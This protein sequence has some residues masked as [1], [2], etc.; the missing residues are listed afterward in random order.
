MGNESRRKSAYQ[1]RNWERTRFEFARAL[2]ALSEKALLEILTSRH[3]RER[4]VLKRT[5]G[6]NGMP[7]QEY[8]VVA[9]EMGVTSSRI[10]QVESR[11]IFS[12]IESGVLEMP[13][14]PTEYLDQ[15]PSDKWPPQRSSL[16]ERMNDTSTIMIKRGDKWIWL[17]S[18]EEV[19]NPPQ[20]TKENTVPNFEVK[21][22]KPSPETV[23]SAK[24]THRRDAALRPGLQEGD[25]RT[26]W[27][28]KGVLSRRGEDPDVMAFEYI[29]YKEAN[30][31][32]LFVIRDI[33]LVEILTVPLP[34]LAKNDSNNSISFDSQGSNYIIRN[35]R[36][37]DGLWM[38]KYKTALPIEA[39]EALIDIAKENTL[40]ANNSNFRPN[41]ELMVAGGFP[42]S[43]IVYTLLYSNGHGDWWR[44]GH[45]WIEG[46]END[47][48][49]EIGIPIAPDLADRFVERFDSERLTIEDS[50]HYKQI[51]EEE[52]L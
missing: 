37:E 13:E 10:R 9:E 51:S 23:G 44:V 48:L 30:G 29:Y 8:K 40:K 31:G 52:F 47:E 7:V 18:G 32:Q 2:N 34:D 26:V 36:E 25:V 22:T 17:D 43:A 4:E 11:T 12:I 6:L 46:A 21:D 14:L 5:L 3:P 15:E 19:A 20:Q 45:D 38:S 39:L 27:P 50:E 28:N 33:G 41:Q 24:N 42:D 35:L 49:P 1:G 16:R